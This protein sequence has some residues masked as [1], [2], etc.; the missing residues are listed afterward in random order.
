MQDLVLAKWEL[1][2]L[3]SSLNRDSN[4]KLEIKPLKIILKLKITS[5]CPNKQACWYL[6]VSISPFLPFIPSFYFRRLYLFYSSTFHF[7]VFLKHNARRQRLK[8]LKAFPGLDWPTAGT[9]HASTREAKR[10]YL[11]SRNWTGHVRIPGRLCET[12][13]EEQKT[14]SQRLS[15]ML[16]YSRGT[17]TWMPLR[18]W[19]RVTC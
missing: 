1:Y 18:V 17:V 9:S 16:F 11:T 2:R 7:L 19:T 4:S 15:E 3:S 5:L 13:M 14:G 6:C 10:G 12:P 8:N